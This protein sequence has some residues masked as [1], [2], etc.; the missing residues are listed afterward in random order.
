MKYTNKYLLTNLNSIHEEIKLELK[1][2][3]QVVTY[4]KTLLSRFLKEKRN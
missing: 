1:Q 2:E 4:S 3:K